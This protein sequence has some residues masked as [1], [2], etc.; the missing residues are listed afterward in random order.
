[1]TREQ[2]A[3]LLG[4]RKNGVEIE[5]GSWTEDRDGDFLSE[6]RVGKSHINERDGKNSFFLTHRVN[7]FFSRTISD[8][9]TGL[10]RKLLVFE[11]KYKI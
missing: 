9:E 11:I 6:E 8:S 10:F 5:R 1:M 3:G 2:R 7:I 4:R